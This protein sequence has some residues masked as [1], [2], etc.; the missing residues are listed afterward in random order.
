MTGLG[1]GGHDCIV[2]C[3]VVGL[4]SAVAFLAGSVGEAAACEP[5]GCHAGS[6]IPAGGTIPKNAAGLRWHLGSGVVDVGKPEKRIAITRDGKKVKFALVPIDGETMRIEIDGGLVEGATYR[7]QADNACGWFGPKKLESTFE[8]GPEAPMPTELGRL[9][10]V[11]AKVDTLRIGTD[12]GSCDVDEK[13]VFADL[14]VV[15][16]PSAAPWKEL[17]DYTATVDGKPWHYSQAINEAPLLGESFLG[18][19][20]DRVYARCQP[21]SFAFEGAGEGKHDVALSGVVFGS[22]ATVATPTVALSLSCADGAA[23]GGTPSGAGADP[24]PPNTTAAEAVEPSVPP[25]DGK[26]SGEA[27]P[28]AHASGCRVGASSWSAWLVLLGPALV[29]RR[30]RRRR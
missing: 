8:V 4:A 5:P 14:E 2:R 19:G 10:A 13:A 12:A 23:L 20:K 3:I 18:R 29:R 27:K 11:T 21:D 6:L 17:I 30:R 16:A 22:S 1:A 7:V 25:D 24:G 26:A 28:G 15:L 9:R